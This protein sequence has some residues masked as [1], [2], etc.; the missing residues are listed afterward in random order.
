M[1][2]GYVTSSASIALFFHLLIV[3]RARNQT[4]CLQGAEFLQSLAGSRRASWRYAADEARDGLGGIRCRDQEHD[5]REMCE[6]AWLWPSE[7]VC[8]NEDPHRR[9]TSERVAETLRRWHCVA[10]DSPWGASLDMHC[11]PE[12][13]RD[14]GATEA[15]LACAVDV[16]RDCHVV[17]DSAYSLA[18]GFLDLLAWCSASLVC[19]CVLALAWFT[20]CC[21]R[22]QLPFPSL[23]EQRSA[24]FGLAGHALKRPEL[25]A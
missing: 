4:G 8:T 15:D 16:A 9:E 1:H 19:C 22:L 18:V 12:A 23:L 5:A 17:F 20:H 11:V 14:S 10:D 2:R 24:L 7:V 21:F 3:A 6:W 25:E 13:D